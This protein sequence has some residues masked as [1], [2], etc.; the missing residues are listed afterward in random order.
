MLEFGQKWLYSG[1][2]GCILASCSCSGKNGW[3][4]R[5]VVVFGQSCCFRVKWLYSGKSGFIWAK[6]VL[7]RPKWLYPGK[8]V[9]FRQIV[10][11]G[12]GLCNRAKWLCSDKSGFI[13]AKVD[14]FGKIGVIRTNCL[15]SVKSGCIRE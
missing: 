6:V 4:S 15:Y 13:R 2:S 11:L 12:Q 1:K 5:T 7:F 8:L 3:F 14:V 9:V 10:V